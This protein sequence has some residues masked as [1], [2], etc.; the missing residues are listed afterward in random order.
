MKQ[1]GNLFGELTESGRVASIRRFNLRKLCRS[2]GLP[3]CGVSF[4][5]LDDLNWDYLQ[6]LNQNLV[7]ERFVFRGGEHFP[8]SYWDDRVLGLD[9]RTE[10]I[11]LNSTGGNQ[12][13]AWRAFFTRNFSDSERTFGSPKSPDPREDC[14]QL[15]TRF[16]HALLMD[17]I[18]FSQH[19]THLSA[20]A[21]FYLVLILL[22]LTPVP[23]DMTRDAVFD[24]F[25]QDFPDY[26]A[27]ITRI[28]TTTDLET[29]LDDI[30]YLLGKLDT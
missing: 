23:E 7:H 4:W 16:R 24:R 17:L 2:F 13:R 9:R 18:H 25:K 5:E 1:V 20:L 12:H 29:R 3:P 11:F 22:T 28:R 26:R 8:R 21:D 30:L 10:F 15:T 27:D 6:T 19:R 14:D